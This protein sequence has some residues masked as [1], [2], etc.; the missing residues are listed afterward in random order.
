MNEDVVKQ[1]ED[2]HL[3]RVYQKMPPVI[4]RG[5]GVHLWDSNG[6]R[7][8]DCMGGYG[9]ALIGHC[10]PKVVEA[11]K[12]QAEKLI[13]CHSS[14]YNDVRAELAATL[15]SM[16]PK[17][18]DTALLC[19]SGAEAVE[20]ALKLARKKSGRKG[21]VAFTGSYHGKTFGALSVTW[22]QKYR[23]PFG[24]LLEQ[25]AFAKYGDISDLQQKVGKDTAAVILEPVQGEAGIHLPPAD[26][27]HQVRELCD[28][29]DV[30]LI[31][32]EIQTGLGRTGRLWASEHWNLRPDI[33]CVAKGI[34]GGIPM[35]AV[36]AAPDDMGVLSVG[37]HTSTFAGGPLAC[38]ASLA[39]LNVIRSEKLWEQAEHVGRHM[40]QGLNR[41][42]D[43][44]KSAREARG[45][46]LMLAL[47]MRFDIRDI[48]F[49]AFG[50]GAAIL[51]S[52]KTILRFLPPLVIQEKEVDEVLTILDELLRIEDTKKRA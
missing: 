26:F 24:P 41:L 35:G 48:L 51:Y 52:G 5:Q 13:T 2:R 46:G 43:A 10:H 11:V 34:G 16:S 39:S 38:A 18:L 19:N 29:K 44:H 30:K 36:L 27:L 40:L 22:G 7:Y 42:K 25:A 50:R 17:G 3:A 1:I 6:K 49:S 12:A 21:F 14:L 8:I 15:T 31:V 23:E 28:T 4:V 9:V 20:A 33:L 37:E 47:E 45:L 32:D